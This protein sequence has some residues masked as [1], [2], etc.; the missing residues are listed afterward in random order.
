MVSF[1]KKPTEEVYQE[2]LK[3]CPYEPMTKTRFTQ[4][5]LKE[6]PDYRVKVIRNGQKV[7]KYYIKSDYVEH[8]VSQFLS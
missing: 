5:F 4:H 6:N 1:I 2:Y 7:E 3:N 8:E